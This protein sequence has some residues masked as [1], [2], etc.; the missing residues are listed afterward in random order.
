[1][2]AKETYMERRN[3]LKSAVGHGLLLFLGND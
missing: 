1:M 3:R 2:F